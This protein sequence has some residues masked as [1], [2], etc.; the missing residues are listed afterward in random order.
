M[1]SGKSTRAPLGRILL[2]TDFAPSSQAAVAYSIGLCRHYGSSL[3]TVTIV[4]QQITDYIQPPD[5]F[6]LRHTADKK[7]TEFAQSERLVG[8]NHRELVMEG[9]V[10]EVIPRLIR[11]LDIDLLVLGTHGYEGI[12]KLVLGSLAEEVINSV[13]C[14]VLTVGPKVALDSL[15]QASLGKILYATSLIHSS[16]SALAYALWIAGQEHARLILLHVL[17]T[18]GKVSQI[19]VQGQRNTSTEQ[20]THLLQAQE[21]LR[22][23]S[24][25]A[26]E[27]GATADSIVKATHERGID[28][29]VMGAHTRAYPII[30]THL[31]VGI[32]HHVICHAIC[33]V[34]TVKD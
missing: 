25:I 17:T 32:S 34:L 31:P 18:A 16:S 4:P 13:Q 19:Q 2:A 30:S 12:K 33:P 21:D 24:E 14:P 7:M 8:I 3:H 1:T 10:A 29:I 11:T 15:P 5:P 22:V 23:E 28:L 27:L 9:L 20:I 6:Y 26:I